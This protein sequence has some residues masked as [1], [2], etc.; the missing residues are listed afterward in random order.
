MI[1][2]SCP[3]FCSYNPYEILEM[4]SKE[5]DHWEIFSEVEHDVTRFD[6]QFTETLKSYGLSYS[7]HTPIS[8]T[9]IA[10]LAPSMMDATIRL[11]ERN[12]ELARTLDI[13]VLTVHPGV[14]SLS[15]PGVKEKSIMAAKKALVALEKLSVEYSVTLAVENM[16][17]FP[18]MMGQTAEEL[19]D[20]MRVTGLDICYDIGHANT[21]GQLDK[22]PEVFK[23]RIANVHIHDNMGDKDAHLTIGQG[24][25]DFEKVLTSLK[26]YKG[27]Y[28]IEAKSFESAVESK[29]VLSKLLNH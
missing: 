18:V 24:N 28:I 17:S 23:G 29:K 1:G 7:I 19:S 10:S 26:G 21:T 15:V 2:V 5:F 8:D 14:Y 3:E 13:D 25:I 12:M 20:L 9:N 6:V 11:F 22:I 16:P 4:V 27:N